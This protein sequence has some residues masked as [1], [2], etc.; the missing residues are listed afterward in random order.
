MTDST[1]A[2]IKEIAV[3]HG[4]AVDRND[5]I[6]IVQTINKRFMDDAAL[7]QQA[8]LDRFKEELEGLSKRWSEDAK[9]KAERILN[10][11][12]AASKETMTSA[13]HEATQS[14]RTTIAAEIDNA[15]AR[16]HT[17]LTNA[18]HLVVIN[19]IAASITLAVACVLL[20]RAGT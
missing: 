17:P 20:W 8:M 10:A 2:L 14:T 18:R 19:I 3:K 6:L 11:S 12:L 16:V 5:P 9:A 1:D 4:I 13:M 15:L 7:A